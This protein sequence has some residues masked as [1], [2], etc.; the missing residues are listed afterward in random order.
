M[1]VTIRGHRLNG[2]EKSMLRIILYTVNDRGSNRIKVM[3]K[4]E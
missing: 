3:E 4:P 2:Y 1:P